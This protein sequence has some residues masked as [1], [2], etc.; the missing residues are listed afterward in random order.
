MHKFL[1]QVQQQQPQPQEDDA[2]VVSSKQQDHN[3][4][5]TAA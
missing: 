3:L 5:H 1:A 4:K 2:T